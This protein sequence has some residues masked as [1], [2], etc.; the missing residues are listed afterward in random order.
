MCAPRFASYTMLI[1]ARGM[2]PFS[3]SSVMC[4]Q[5]LSFES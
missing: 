3:Q 5:D 1:V 4:Y 2:L